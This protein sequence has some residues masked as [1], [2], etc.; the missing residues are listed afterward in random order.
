MAKSK[1]VKK[2]PFYDK[3]KTKAGKPAKLGTRIT[4]SDGVSKVLLTPSGKGAKYSAELKN[5]KHYTNSGVI[6]RDNDGNP[7][8]LDCCQRSYHAGYLAARK[9]GAKAYKAKKN[10]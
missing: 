5:D 4:D 6:K 3:A 9:N 8:N 7:L 10:K 2:E 1:I